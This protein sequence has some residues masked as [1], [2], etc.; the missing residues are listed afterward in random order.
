MIARSAGDRVSQM[1]TEAD[2]RSPI[3]RNAR[4]PIPP[5][6]AALI[7]L[8]AFGSAHAIE[9][10]GCRNG[11][12]PALGGLRMAHVAPVAEGRRYACL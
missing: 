8:C 12:F 2:C 9:P 7:L 1:T 3:S 5:R 11:F 10:Y 4:M 6:L